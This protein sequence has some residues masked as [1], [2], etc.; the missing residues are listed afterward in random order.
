MQKKVNNVDF[1]PRLGPYSHIVE[2]GELIY[3]SGILPQDSEGNVI[4]D[5][6]GKATELTLNNISR[7]L[8]S[9]GSNLE[10]V[11]KVTVFLAE[12]DYFEQMNQVYKVFFP[13]SPPAR[14]CVA[15]KAL[16]KGVQLEIEVIAMK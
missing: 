1:L 12:M 8:Q 9:V 15:V 14:T 4:V 2:A 6:V 16:P 10:K 3:L 13:S 11:V 5:N 7:A